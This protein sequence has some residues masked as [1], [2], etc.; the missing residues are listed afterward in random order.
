MIKKIFQLSLTPLWV[1]I[2][3]CLLSLSW[4]LP[5]HS[6]PW[7]SFHSDAWMA[8]VLAVIGLVIIVRSPQIFFLRGFVIIIALLTILPFIQYR[9]G[10]I[11]FAG[12]AWIAS[13]YL[14]GFLMA[15]LVG[16]RWHGWCPVW[17]GDFL[18][19]AIGIASIVSVALQ[20]QQWLGLNRDGTLDIWILSSDGIRPYANMGQPNQ[21]ATLLLWGLL[22]LAWGVWRRFLGRSVAL[23]SAAFFLYGLVLTQSRTGALGLL[24]LVI[25]AWYWKKLWMKSYAH[26][27]VTGLAIFYVLFIWLLSPVN[28][29]LMLP[30]LLS[31]GDRISQE[32]RPL[33]WRLLLDAAWQHP[34]SG[35][36]INQVFPAQLSVAERYSA[37]NVPF[38]QS[39][40]LFI[41]LIL[42]TGIPIGLFLMG[43]LIAWINIAR[44]RIIRPQEV[45]Y[46]LFIIVVGVHA[47]LEYPLHYAYFLLPTGL[48]IGALNEELK[49]W[50][51]SYSFRLVGRL[52]LIGLWCL[53]ISLLGII[54]RDYFRIESNYMA[55]EIKKA[56][57]EN[58]KIV[59]APDV[60]LLT[61]LRD[62][63]EFM[64]SKPNIGI[65]KIT[66]QW[67]RDIT[68]ASP[69][70]RN[71]MALSILL[72]LNNET[73]EAR[74][75]L[76]KMCLIVSK[77]QCELS[78]ANW[79][80]AQKI[81]PQ[82]RVINW[83]EKI[84]F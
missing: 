15:L 8:V 51:F 58:N 77:D 74:E 52:V 63:Q 12:Q 31:N 24:I 29:L 13:A 9:F 23:L 20:L 81:Y 49:I 40:N 48:I 5:N 37:V 56:G 35:Y 53:S 55:F 22:A 71:F 30:E 80:S 1:V 54:I 43:S 84:K 62:I 69:S 3:V 83:P 72:G 2:G 18:F 32:L 76:V 45:F 38:M 6:K 68:R 70:T 17:M 21:L 59:K 41:D 75:W 27:Y 46:F 66:L 50:Q 25:A 7:T 61:D 10:V 36:G 26:L 14:L 65:S 60:M 16:E 67:A 42:W 11:P 39:H 73:E 33:I 19:S 57:I 64:N 44:L 28:R 82:L 79:A 34:F 4:I 47:M 78:Y